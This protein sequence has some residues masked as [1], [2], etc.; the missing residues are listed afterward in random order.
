MDPTTL[1]KTVHEILV[2]EF[3]L[4]PDDIRPGAR[5]REDLEL[6]SLDRVDLIVS[7]EKAL[8]LRFGEDQ[9]KGVE[10]VG[11]LHACVKRVVAEA[12]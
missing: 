8:D 2:D 7:L 11:D 6:D 9:V 3:E 4:D 10:T 12:S 5:L 1:Q